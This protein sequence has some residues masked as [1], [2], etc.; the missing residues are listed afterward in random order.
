MFQKITQRSLTPQSTVKMAT[1]WGDG[2]HP[3]HNK[4]ADFHVT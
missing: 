4:E 2:L 3:K 1:E